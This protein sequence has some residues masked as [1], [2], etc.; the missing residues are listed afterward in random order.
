[1]RYSTA[2]VRGQL[3]VAVAMLACCLATTTIR[4]PGAE[5]YTPGG[6]PTFLWSS[7]PQVV[8]HTLEFAAYGG[9]DAAVT[10]ALIGAVR[11]VNTEFNQVG[12]TRSLIASGGEP[13]ISISPFDY[14]TP[15]FDNVLAPKIHI[16]FTNNPSDITAIDG[17]LSIAGTAQPTTCPGVTEVRMVFLAPD[18]QSWNFSTPQQSGEDYATVGRQDSTGAEWFRQVYLHE[19]LHAFGLGHSA[20]SYSY[21]NGGGNEVSFPW[22]NG[23]GPR[24]ARPLPDDVRF[25]R[26]RYGAAGGRSE[27]AVLN[28]WFDPS[29]VNLGA[30]PQRFNC[31]PSLGLSDS[32]IF[33][34]HC[35]T[36]GP[37]SGSTNVCPNDI[38]R[39]QFTV[40]NYSTAAVDLEAQIYLSTDEIRDVQ[41]SVSVT[42]RPISIVQSDSDIFA[43]SWRVPNADW[44][45]YN[46]IVRVTGETTTGDPVEDWIPLPGGVFM[47]ACNGAVEGVPSHSESDDASLDLDDRF[48]P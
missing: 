38:L 48:L 16:G 14:N 26:D 32:A 2:R 18:L 41:D 3:V 8:I 44:G 7:P 4:P 9:D 20:N 35:G 15:Y 36:G 37:D 46:V 28:T 33:S 12:G 22:A 13:S 34:A 10:Q 47:G 29:Q 19:L 31:A 23:T 21:M 45:R 1:M 6:C 39:T 30:A 42:S 25:L 24:S 11:K 5:A 27:V 43:R 17:Q 40:A